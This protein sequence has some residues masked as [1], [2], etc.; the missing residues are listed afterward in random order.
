MS[1]KISNNTKEQ[2]INTNKSNEETSNIAREVNAQLK[3][4]KKEKEI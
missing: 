4:E 2:N 3:E 1:N